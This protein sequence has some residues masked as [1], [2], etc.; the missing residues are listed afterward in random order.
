M[1]NS[2]KKVGGSNDYPDPAPEKVGGSKSRKTQR[3]Y[4]PAP[5]TFI[6]QRLIVLNAD[7]ILLK[8]PFVSELELPKLLSLCETEY[9][10]KQNK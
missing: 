8:A 5:L 3:I 4:T 9:I 2:S 7:N 10:V 1:K 6:V